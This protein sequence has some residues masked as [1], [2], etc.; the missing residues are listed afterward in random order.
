[1]IPAVLVVGL[2]TVLGC[3]KGRVIDDA[4][5]ASVEAF[6]V[7]WGTAMTQAQID[8]QRAR[9]E[10][11][12][13]QIDEQRG[14]PA[15]ELRCFAQRIRA[16]KKCNS[17]MEETEIA[18]CIDNAQRACEPSELFIGATHACPASG[19]VPAVSGT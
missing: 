16:M 17:A 4:L 6:P 3:E 1:V 19:W 10:C 7:L 2:G 13:V 5:D 15:N 12:W 14:K 8:E 18:A 9:L 11:F